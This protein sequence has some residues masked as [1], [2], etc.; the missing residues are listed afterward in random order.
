MTIGLTS[1]NPQEGT[2]SPSSLT[3]NVQNG[4]NFQPVVIHGLND[5]EGDA[6]ELHAPL[7][8]ALREGHLIPVCFVSAR[9]GAG[10]AELLDLIVKL[11]IDIHL[12]V[13][14][15]DLLAMTDRVY[16]A[17]LDHPRIREVRI[18][19][20]RAE[21]GV[22]IGIAAHPAP[23]GVWS[24]TSRSSCFTVV[25]SVSMPNNSRIRQSACVVRACDPAA[26]S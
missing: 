8:K 9:T 11:D 18:T 3:F 25:W 6:T 20:Y 15:P 7:E 10:V 14:S 5:G 21:G 23:S 22:K 2:V 19:D 24:S 26:R 13:D 4:T 17:L 1:S 12:L 16:H